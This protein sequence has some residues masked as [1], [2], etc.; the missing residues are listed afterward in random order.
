MK[1]HKVLLLIYFIIIIHSKDWLNRSGILY[2]HGTNPGRKPTE[3]LQTAKTGEN[4]DNR[5][6]SQPGYEKTPQCCCLSA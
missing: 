4:K 5:G 2:S 1:F 3:F 6:G